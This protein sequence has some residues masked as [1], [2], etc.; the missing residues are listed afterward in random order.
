VRD[1]ASYPLAGSQPHLLGL[2]Q[3]GGEP[4]A[5]VDLHALLTGSQPRPDH[6]TTL[7]VKPPTGPLRG[8]LGLA[9]DEAVNVIRLDPK[10]HPSR[11]GALVAAET[12]HDGEALVILDPAVLFDDDWQ[13]TEGFD[14][15]R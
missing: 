7:I 5:I 4:L 1:L 15:R 11:V 6:R 3:Y 9:V 2:S 12:H 8:N 10:D 14:G 13:P